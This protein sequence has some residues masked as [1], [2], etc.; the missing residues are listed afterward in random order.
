MA[1]NRCEHC[2]EHLLDYV[3]GLLEG[4]DLEEART[5]LAACSSCQ[6][7][8]QTVQS[9]QK[10]MARA[11]RAVSE[12]AE[13]ALPAAPPAPTPV[14][15]PMIEKPATARRPLWRRPWVAWAAAAAVLIAAIAP[16]WYYRVSVDGY[17]NTLAEKRDR[18]R[19]VAE[20][21]AALPAKYEALDKAAVAEVRGKASPY[22]HVVGPKTL[23]PGAKA[24]M[25]IFAHHVEGT[26]RQLK[27]E[28]GH[29]N[30]RVRVSEVQ[31]GNSERVVQVFPQVKCDDDGL[32]VVELDASKVAASTT[33]KVIVD[34]DSGRSRVE[35][36]VQVL[37]PTYATRIDTN[38]IGYQLKDVLFFRVL[39]LNRYTLQPPAQPLALR[40]ELARDGQVV[41]SL[42]RSTADGGIIAGE[43][44][45]DEKFAE[46]MYTLIARPANPATG[47]LQTA[48]QRLEIAREPRPPDIQFDRDDY[49]PG[50]IVR[51]GIML[52]PNAK[53]ERVLIDGVPVPVTVQ[54]Q[55]L[56]APVPFPTQGAP[57]PKALVNPPPA[58]GG[59][60]GVPR[61]FEFQARI[62]DKL[63]SA[64]KGGVPFALQ[65]ADG[66]KKTELRGN[67]PIAPTDFTVDFFPEGGDLIAGVP[68]RVFYRVRSKTGEPITGEGR[69][70]LFAGAERVIPEADSDYH[71]G[72]GYID[73][74]PQPRQTYVV[75]IKTSATVQDLAEP[76]KKLGMQL[77][78]VVIQVSDLGDDHEP[79]AVGNQG[80]PIRLTLRQQG[81]ARKLLV[82]A[83]CRGQIV[84]QRWID[85]K[86]DPVDITL[87][88][89]HEAVGMIR[90]TAYALGDTGLRPIA[91]RLV[92][93]A[94]TQRLD[95]GFALNTQQ[96]N[97]GRQVVAKVTA[98][99]EKGDPAK[100]WVLASVVDERLQNVPR[101]LSAHFYLLNEIRTGA[102]LDNAQLILHDSPDSAQVLERFLG[103]HGWRRFG[104]A[105]E[106]GDGKVPVQP[107]VFSREN[108]PLE[109]LQKKYEESLAAAQTPMQQRLE[110]RQKLED[111]RHDALTA[112][113]LA[114]A[115]LNAFEE[116]FQGACRFA[117]GLVVVSL[118][119]ASL[120]LMGYGLY[121]IIRAGSAAPAFGGSFAC[122][123]TC[124]GLFF[125]STWIGPASVTPQ[126]NLAAAHG[127]PGWEI[128]ADLF[129]RFAQVMPGL[130]A[131]AEKVATGAFALHVAK[132][133][134]RADAKAAGGTEKRDRLASASTARGLRDRDALVMKF[135]NQRAVKG[136]DAFFRRYAHDKAA[137]DKAPLPPKNGKKGEAMKAEK[138]ADRPEA[139]TQY[140]Y[141]FEPNLL[142]DTLL[143]RPTLWLE[144]GS[145]D[146]R[147]DIAAGSATYRVLLLGHTPTGRFGFYETRLDV[148]GR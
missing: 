89:T 122:L 85:L 137:A 90:V 16:A 28:T 30:V 124:L 32:A 125:L 110:E 43:F 26:P 120:A 51:G 88:P 68:N 11:A 14:T 94:P 106:L 48:M 80:D 127:A 82:A 75:R 19:Q 148:L 63:R 7:A 4:S 105:D 96:I 114:V 25:H 139:D 18:H 111:R 118:F 84:D 74:T 22:L 128:K 87:Q 93:R 5:H 61:M 135:E 86:R 116:S 134:E 133:D 140:A 9:Q 108:L 8:L 104:R 147:F 107:H 65:V 115:E 67:L 23:Q 3:Y 27:S 99:D 119:G 44:A 83:Q 1:M 132:E 130:G 112:V 39:V 123:L 129:Q 34:A 136:T 46:G 142:A 33:L 103:T 121:R 146:V 73:F 41:R 21:F 56:A 143:W 91:E 76:F 37:A 29:V 55:A 45:I 64:G 131:P 59:F 12:V 49:L 77:D 102:D 109:A 10:L 54:P 31:Q 24:H 57:A 2:K 53:A 141:E 50:Q 144:A 20:Q 58:A 60:G 62:P 101:S 138:I 98:R 42:T 97:A 40:V 38:K 71:L 100:A 113:T 15:L 52:G 66:N 13:F 70:M 36:T 95:L 79:K 92:Y 47:N 69:V 78:G 126:P 72:M 6:A 17:K 81:P 117:L 35:E 145:A